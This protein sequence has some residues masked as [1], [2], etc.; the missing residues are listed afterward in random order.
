MKAFGVRIQTSSG[1]GS[2]LV[3][4]SVQYSHTA[5]KRI[6]NTMRNTLDQTLLL[7]P[8]LLTQTMTRCSFY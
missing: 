4:V 6:A 5:K 1:A 8:H 7:R 2:A 3:S